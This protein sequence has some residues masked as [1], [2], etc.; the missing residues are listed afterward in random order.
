MQSAIPILCQLLGSKSGSDITEAIDFFVAAH[1]FGLSS[2]SQGIRKMIMLM[3]TSEENV[4]T[5]VVEAY[6]KLYLHPVG[7]DGHKIK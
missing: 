3:W 2:A 5:A 7:V 4:K 1:Q 6:R